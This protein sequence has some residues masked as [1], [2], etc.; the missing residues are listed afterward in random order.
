MERGDVKSSITVAQPRLDTK[1]NSPAL[2]SV[3]CVPAL[4]SSQPGPMDSVV[5]QSGVGFFFGF[6][7]KHQKDEHEDLQES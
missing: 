3:W 6:W 1:A 4:A 2:I 7:S 5:E